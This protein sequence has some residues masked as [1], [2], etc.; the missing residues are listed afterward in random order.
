MTG[1]VGPAAG[2][3][4]ATSPNELVAIFD[5]A[6]GL[7]G[8]TGFDFTKLKAITNELKGGAL[9]LGIADV[10]IQLGGAFSGKVSFLTLD[11]KVTTFTAN[12]S[13]EGQGMEKKELTLERTEAGVITG[14][15][16][17]AV[18]HKQ[19]SGSI[20][21][22]WDGRALTGTGKVGY[23]GEK[24][25]GEV[26]IY[27]MEKTKAEELEQ[28]KQAPPEEAKGPVV[29]APAGKAPAKGRA[30][31]EDYVVFGEGDLT[32]AFNEWLNGT[33][34]VI[35]DH[36]G[37]LTVIGQITPQAEFILFKQQDYD[38]E[39]FKAEMRAT[40]GV[41]V[42]G[43]LFIF[44]NVS[45]GAFAK[46]GPGK[47]HKIVID[48]TY[49]TDPKK[50]QSFSV[51]CSLNVS[52]AAGLRLRGEAGAGIE[53]LSHDLKAGAGINALA[54]IRGYA[55]ATPVIGYRE[56]AAEGGADK[57]GE[58]FIKGDLE[59]AA[60]PFLGLSGDLFVEV[61]APWWSPVPDKKWT[62][63]IGQKEWPIGG[64]FGVVASVEHILGSGQWPSIE[65][66]PVEFSADKFLTDLYSDKAPAKSGDKG[67]QPGTWK[68]KNEKAAEPPEKG[69]AK[70]VPP[71]KG[72]LPR[73]PSRKLPRRRPT[74]LARPPTRTPARRRARASRSS[75]TRPRRR[76][77][78][79]RAR[80][81]ER[82]RART[83]GRRRTP[84]RR[85]TTSWWRTT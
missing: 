12:V 18:A 77:R 17:V 53:I 60:Q 35:I 16:M 33:A 24:F 48:G 74:N 39:L 62:W 79:P 8:L 37:D 61:D 81:P 22:A 71:G 56:Q 1:Y 49:S 10:D 14:K 75:K 3:K 44:G 72:G 21:I 20:D 84:A 29:V 23:S 70:G 63:P 45:L 78:S 57:K 85:S 26:T 7:L 47:L 4:I 58:F 80:R 51:Q 40:Y 46:I 38:K 54:G 65:F 73:P 11:G 30:K 76:A 69:A 68:E 2:K 6:P 50:A 27:L 15:V 83:R 25:S 32:F 41:P 28:Q 64:S 55:E 59:I 52:A 67:E 9:T 19:V 5:K 36:K 34:H 13:V 82:A 42:V 43:N 66:K 31:P